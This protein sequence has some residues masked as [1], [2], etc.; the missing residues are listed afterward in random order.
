MPSPVGQ[1]RTSAAFR[2]SSWRCSTAVAFLH[3]AMERPN[4]TV[5]PYT[6]A[7][8][9][10]FDGTRAT[11]VVGERLG[12]ETEYRAGR[13]VLLCGGA[14]NSPHLLM[15]SGVGPAE[16]LALGG[17]SGRLVRT[18]VLSLHTSPRADR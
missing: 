12:E 17:L 18:D 10:S 2:A 1:A 8:R 9:I 16:R 3:P 15:L 13:E 5:V 6:R 14:Y 11:G 4:L 7:M